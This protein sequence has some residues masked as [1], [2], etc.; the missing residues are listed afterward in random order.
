LQESA[1]TW[2]SKDRI[3]RFLIAVIARILVDRCQHH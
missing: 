2:M 3:R 1:K